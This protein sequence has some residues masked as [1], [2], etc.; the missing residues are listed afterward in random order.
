MSERVGEWRVESEG[1]C[2]RWEVGV[3]Q[4]CTVQAKK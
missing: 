2:S 3:V 1:G 4:L